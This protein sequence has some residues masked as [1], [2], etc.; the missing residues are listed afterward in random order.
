MF[1]VTRPT[2]SFAFCTW[3]KYLSLT[4]QQFKASVWAVIMDSQAEAEA[5]Q[6]SEDERYAAQ[7]AD[8]SQES[9]GGWREEDSLEERY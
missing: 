9:E 7:M 2:S 5:Q 3:Y 1:R 6:A 4:H 8:R